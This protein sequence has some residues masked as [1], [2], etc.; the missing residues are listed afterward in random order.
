M[1]DLNSAR[2][3]TR[4]C[5]LS[6]LVDLVSLNASIVALIRSSSTLNFSENLPISTS[7]FGALLYTTGWFVGWFC[8]VLGVLFFG[9]MC[10]FILSKNDVF[11]GGS[12]VVLLSVA[13]FVF[14]SATSFSFGV[15]FGVLVSVSDGTTCSVCCACCVCT[16][17]SVGAVSFDGVFAG[18]LSSS[19][20][21][22]SG[23]LI[24]K[25]LS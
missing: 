20:F 3:S 14:I 2:P 5:I 16:A 12:L 10:C 8:T 9:I 24:P 15:S 23:I 11:L 4:V 13:S 22:I 6:S 21:F 25:S 19:V 1:L 7:K 18:F 17:C